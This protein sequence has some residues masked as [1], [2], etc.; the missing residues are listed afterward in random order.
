[1]MKKIVVLTSTRAEYGLL[2]PVIKKLNE[3]EDVDVKVAVTGMHLSK[4]HGLTYRE[5]EKDGVKI[6]KKIEILMAGDTAISVS[7]SMGLAMIGFSEYF[8]DAKP[9]A[10]LVLGD[11]YEIMAVCCTAM[12]FRIP[13]IHI[14][15]G[16]TT[17]GAID[18]AVRHSITKM[19]YLHF[20]STEEY[21]KRVIQLGESPDRVFNVGG[22]GVENALHT[23][24]L[25]KNELSE[26]L[27]LDLSLPYSMITYHPVTLEEGDLEKSI[28]K[29]FSALD[30]HNELLHI[31]TAANSDVGG[32][33]INEM[34]NDY[35]ASRN[36]VVV[37]KSLGFLRYLSAV[38]YS[39]VVIGNS[40]SGLLEAPSLKIPTVNIGDRQKGRIKADTVI[41][42]AD[43][44][45]SI[46]DAIKKA[47]SKEFKAVCR[48]AQNPYEGVDT[49]K[50][51]AQLTY[52][53]VLNRNVNLKKRFYDL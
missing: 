48:V 40:S 24:L 4:E 12:N 25:T 5:I 17:E 3:Y 42:C 43:D 21:R 7:K 22:L 18:E 8:E 1:M 23:K 47:L 32:K 37:F 51:I 31:F 2:A 13:I 16:E 34:I 49:S 26:S 15:G 28:K 41:D 35:A 29:L 46:C 20:T 14:H 27:N 45:K 39:E 33:V 53:N 9:D 38:K 44:E 50:K 52:D 10:L 30:K 19:S 6:D 36:N 11:R